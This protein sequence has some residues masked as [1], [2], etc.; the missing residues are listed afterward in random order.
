L[1]IIER[2]MTAF[3]LRDYAHDCVRKIRASF[4]MVRPTTIEIE[5][6]SLLGMWC[7]EHEVADT[8]DL[9]ALFRTYVREAL[10]PPF[11]DP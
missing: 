4:P 9:R 2:S 5:N 7:A 3:L 1:S 8:D 11:T 6:H 10:D